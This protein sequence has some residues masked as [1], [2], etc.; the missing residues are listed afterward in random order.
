[1]AALFVERSLELL[2]VDGITVLLLPAKLWQSLSG[3]GVRRFL[4]EN[5]SLIA[6]HDLSEAPQLFDAAVYPSIIVARRK[7]RA[8]HADDRSR[9]PLGKASCTETVVHRAT[10]VERWQTRAYQLGVDT[11]PGSP[12][13]LLPPQVRSAFDRVTQA[14]IPLARTSIGRP[15]LGVKTGCNDAFI[16]FPRDDGACYAPP[17]GGE[18]T[19]VLSAR[20]ERDLERFLLRPLLR[21]EQVTAWNVT[22][23]KGRIIWTHD[24]GG[25]PVRS[26]PPAALHCLSQWRRDLERRVDARGKPRWWMLFRT[27]SADSSVARVVWADIGRS[28]RAA[29]I[30]AGDDT[31]PLN[32]CYVA[33]CAALD[34]ALALTALLNSSLVAAWLNALAEPARGGYRRYLGW[35]MS[36]LPLPRDWSRATRILAPIA[37]Q[38]IG[39]N[40][41]DR[42]SLLA[43][44]QAS[45][46]LSDAEVAPLLQWRR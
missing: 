1:V 26:L 2:R 7:P 14:G 41:P 33:R 32:T 38:A 28:P 34:D 45:Y 5:S 46:G 6:I 30:P 29:L 10:C 27:E 31:V 37:E 44:V 13:L 35:T 22:G 15:L 19:R 11:S 36:M 17:S 12:W 16:V 8:N 40:P 24:S 21:G 20:G 9:E 42:G 39:G 18:L 25:D 4:Q 43:A 3:G 23:A